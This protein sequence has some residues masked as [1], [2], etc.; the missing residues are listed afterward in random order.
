MVSLDFETLGPRLVNCGNVGRRPPGDPTPLETPLPR[1]PTPRDPL[2]EG[3]MLLRPI[4][5]GQSCF[6]QQQKPK[7]K[8]PKRGKKNQ[9]PFGPK[10][11]RQMFHSKPLS[12]HLEPDSAPRTPPPSPKKIALFS[13]PAPCS[14][15]FFGGLLVERW[16]QVEAVVSNCGLRLLWSHFVKLRPE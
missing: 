2:P 14:L 9:M 3:H 7:T 10:L 16:P 12:R 6:G 13:P 15:S 4:Q 5:L 11:F 1:R 8:I